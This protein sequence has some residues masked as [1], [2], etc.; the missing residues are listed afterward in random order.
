MTGKPEVARRR[1]LAAWLKAVRRIAIA[2]LVAAIGASAGAQEL[3]PGIRKIVTKVEFEGNRVITEPAIRLR[4]RTTEGANYNEDTVNE[5]VKSLRALGFYNVR[6]F[7]EAYEGG[8]K[9]RFELVE[10]PLV[11]DV[12]FRGLDQISRKEID[13]VVE[14]RK[15]FLSAFDLDVQTREIQSFYRSRGFHFAEVD[16]RLQPSKKGYEVVI[17]VMFTGNR[18]LD[19]SELLGVMETKPSTLF[20][21]GLFEE[22]TLFQDVVA[23]RNAYRAHG[24]R[25]VRVEI[26]RIDFT[27]D[28]SRVSLRLRIEEGPLYTVRSVRI[29]G[30]EVIPDDQILAKVRLQPGQAYLLGRR[31]MD[32]E[33]IQALYQNNA[34]VQAQV[35]PRETFS[36]TGT[37]VDV[38]YEIEE[39]RKFNVGDI[40]ITGNRLTK[41]EVIRRDLSF[42]PGEPVNI[43][44]IRKS[45]GRLFA[46]GYFDVEGGLRFEPDTRVNE[47][48]QDWTIAVKEGRTGN[49]RFAAGVGSDSGLIGQ[50]SIS[51]KNFDIADLPGSFSD[52]LEGE[53]FTGAGQTV[54]LD[55]AP[56]T[57]F[58]QIGIG[59][60]EPHVFG[61]DNSFGIDIVRRFRDRRA[62][63]EIRTGVDLSVGRYLE[64][65]RRDIAVELRFRNELVKIRNLDS[66]L[67]AICDR[68][69][70]E[71]PDC[72]AVGT[73]RVVAIGPSFTWRKVDSPLFPSDGYELGLSYEVGGG[74]LGGTTDM[75]RAVADVLRYFPVYE[76]ENE[77]KHV[78]A[79]R[80]RVGWMSG[81]GDTPT[82]PIYERFF[83]GGR[84]SIRGFEFR[85]AG[86][87]KKGEPVGG[88][89]IVTGAVE[90][91]FP[92]YEEIFRGVLFVDY[93]TVAETFGALSIDEM[94]VSAGFGVRFRVPFLGPVPFAFDFGFPLRREDDD[95][96]QVVSFSLGQVFF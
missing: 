86:P 42:H 93:G 35:V 3:P 54:Y 82:V 74:I 89:G 1:R 10:S 83:A 81:F 11:T 69:G 73:N 64:K 78:L 49:L 59:F 13:D 40:R 45:F 79:A 12:T 5:D 88:Q 55:I 44:E 24:Y 30:N 36:E 67:R 43:G 26:D 39:G 9:V 50:I 15:G 71:I 46:L 95:D 29:A 77:L 17:D 41:D 7:R 32:R 20:T 51:K 63:D 90:Y 48:V 27:A 53:A 19:T 31:D 2:G 75:N 14:I 68:R 61:S 87:H 94:R 96:L 85:G 65:F 18:A 4:I 6:V 92:I 66:D 62:Y 72:D 37:E 38:R 34:Y 80:I 28:K 56:G 52:V 58:S 47:G 23:L 21:K 91:S 25:D 57:R 16:Y 76:Q 33:A 84:T 60:R 70:D 8:V 22:R